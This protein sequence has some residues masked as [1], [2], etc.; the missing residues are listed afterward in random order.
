MQLDLLL[1]GCHNA[2][3]LRPCPVVPGVD[4]CD[5]SH[6]VYVTTFHITASSTV[7]F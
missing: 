1:N 6:T 2:G 4:C 5:S 3:S 7:G